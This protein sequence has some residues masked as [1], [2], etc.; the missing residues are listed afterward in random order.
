MKPCRHGRQ[1]FIAPHDLIRAAMPM[2]SVPRQAS[3]DRI[4][5]MRL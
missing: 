1:G 3:Y 5:G 4:G 2:V